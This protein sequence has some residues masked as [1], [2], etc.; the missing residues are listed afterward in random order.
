MKEIPLSRG[1]VA[2]VD[3]GDYERVVQVGSWYADPNRR[4]FYARHNYWT[5]E[6]KCKALKMHRFIT[7]W[8]YVDH[9]NGDGLDNRRA[10]LRPVTS[11]QNAQNRRRRSDNTS[12]FKGVSPGRGRGKWEATVY[13][14]GQRHHLGTFLRPEDA[15]RAYDSAAAE[16]FGQFARLNFPK[17][18]FHV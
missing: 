17:E 10:N 1:L 7:G 5:P 6:R 3:D 12:G 16:L 11:A 18:H 14:A 15:A 13:S 9:I 4:T 2:L 8:D